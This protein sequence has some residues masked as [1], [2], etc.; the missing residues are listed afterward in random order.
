MHQKAK[1]IIHKTQNFGPLF[2]S[3]IPCNSERMGIILNRIWCISADRHPRMALLEVRKDVKTYLQKK[4]NT[5]VTVVIYSRP[6]IESISLNFLASVSKLS[7]LE[8]LGILQLQ[9]PNCIIHAKDIITHKQTQEI[10]RSTYNSQNL[11]KFLTS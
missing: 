3:C 7:K 1:L 6:Y 5:P 11:F 9:F 10:L 2:Y 8:E 4:K